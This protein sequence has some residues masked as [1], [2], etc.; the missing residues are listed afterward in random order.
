MGAGFSSTYEDFQKIAYLNGK[1]IASGWLS[2]LK[3][4]TINNG[5]LTFSTSR[6][7]TDLVSVLGYASGLYFASGNTVTQTTVGS[8]TTTA[9]TPINL[10]SID[11]GTWKASTP[12]SGMNYQ[13]DGIFFNNRLISV[14]SGGAIYQSNSLATTNNAP[15]ITS[16][17][18]QTMRSAR[19][20]ITLAV[21][22]TD[23][24]GDS[25]NYRWDAGDGIHSGTSS[26]F[27]N[28]Y[29]AGGT[30]SVSVTV[31]DGKGGSV[32]SGTS[33]VVSDPAQ[34]F[35][36]VS[37][38]SATA[39]GTVTLNGIASSGSL[40]VAVGDK[41]KVVTST[42]GKTWTDRTLSSPTNM[43]LQGVAWDGTRFVA[44]GLDYASGWVGV[45]HTSTDG[46]SWSKKYTSSTSS[47]SINAFRSVVGTGGTLLVGG[48]AGRLLRS[49]DGGSAWTS[50][51]SGAVSI[52]T[53]HSV[54]GL[55][56]GSGTF[57]ATSHTYNSVAS[58]DGQIYTSADGSTWTTKTSGSGLT[59]STDIN[60]I[61]YLNNRFVGSGWY[62]KLRVSTDNGATFTTTRSSTE[63]TP[64]LAYGGGVYLAAGVDQDSGNAKIHVLSTDGTT[65]TQSSA[66]TGAVSEK[67]ATFFNNTF[68]IV[69]G[70]G[71]I[72]QSGSLLS[73]GS[74]EIL[75]QPTAL[76]LDEGSTAAFS[77]LAVGSGTLSYQWKK[78]GTAIT[79]GTSSSY[80]IPSAATTDSGSYSVQITDSATSTS[81]TSASVGLLVKAVSLQSGTLVSIQPPSNVPLIKGSDATLAISLYAPPNGTQTTY[82]L[83]SGTATALAVSGSVSA[84]GV[85]YIPLKSLTDSGS[86]SV[87]FER[88]SASG[89][90]YDFSKP[91]NLTFATWDSALGTYQTLL[92]NGSAA[93]TALNDGSDYRG[94]L[95]VTVNRGGS[96]SGRLLY[97]EATLLSG[98]TSG[99]RVYAPIVRTFAGRLA[100]KVGAPST[101]TLT[102]KLGTTA[103]ASRQSLTMELD[104]SSAAPT[105]S[106]TLSDFVS[107]QSGTCVSTTGSITKA[108]T[109][110]SA[111]SLS[112]LVGKYLLAANVGEQAYVQAQVVS[113]GRV[114]WSTRL[115]GYTGTGTG[116]LNTTDV[117]NPSLSLYEG[118][119]VT[120]TKLHNSTSL[121]AELNFNISSGSLWAASL[122]SGVLE[123]QASYLLRSVSGTLGTVPVYSG[124][125]FALGTNSTGVTKLSFSHN[126]GARWSGTSS[127]TLPSFLPTATALTL[128]VVDP[129]V[130]G[131]SLTY[132][133]GITI[134]TSAVVRAVS[135]TASDGTTIS[136]VFRPRLDRTTGLWSGFYIA[137]GARRTVVGA[138]IDSGTGG[139]RAAQGWIET[140]VVP[141]L[142]T[143]TWT[144]SK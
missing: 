111:G 116:Y 141:S 36:L 95:T 2:G 50:V 35:T 134:S 33:L 34:S 69:G 86:Y 51:S 40:A 105:L 115:K 25:L 3:T 119:Q 46:I 92:A 1:F 84:T 16:L 125:L 144:L 107:L 91:F 73:G 75:T 58:G 24:D 80:T 110:L 23:A 120:S 48:D 77:V 123:K 83:Y 137:S 17:V 57:V 130:S 90:I 118:R 47:S 42:D 30:Y 9:Y 41:G 97:N 32:T 62:S 54:T 4:G 140:G 20:P 43:H 38:G 81:L 93:A 67:A 49:T 15:V 142:S 124:S 136:P 18:A 109:S 6:T 79:G 127:A 102:P 63:L 7:E 89:K 13:K 66:P 55:A 11:G 56:Y 106:A 131:P 64:A 52:S 94:L 114:L 98:G 87:R 14:G 143:G 132:S 74:L 112:T 44:V 135:N 71:Q 29:A 96:V 126:N 27:T 78:D 121:L 72:W 70:S 104:I 37:G 117:A 133:W 19:A 12:I 139:L 138:S 26:V 39:S 122:D 8:N 88:S 22:A 108:A 10:Y 5:T 59:S 101:V 53:A 76:T 100:P 103:Q 61:A 45:I 21:S 99:E 31:N 129:Q 65:W 68:L 85:A 128:S 113:S 82:T 60:S 28:T